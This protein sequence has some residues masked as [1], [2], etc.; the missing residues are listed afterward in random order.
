ME[1]NVLTSAEVNIELEE[2]LP[3]YFIRKAQENFENGKTIWVM[4]ALTEES[5]SFENFEDETR[6][7][8]SFLYKRGMRKGDTAIY[9]T[10]DMVHNHVFFV[11]V[12]RANGIVRAS[13]PE[14]DEGIYMIYKY[15]MWQRC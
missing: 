11:G 1:D 7:I 8:A 14:D 5:H 6:K 12:W 10:V 15:E 13:Y 2:T 3:E 9:M 4:D